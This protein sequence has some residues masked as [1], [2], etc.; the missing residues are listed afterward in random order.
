M[1]FKTNFL[2][3]VFAGIGSE[4]LSPISN[5]A[6]KI[7]TNWIHHHGP[8][9]EWKMALVCGTPL[10][11][12]PSFTQLK[13]LGILHLIVISGA[14]LVFFERF[15]LS[16][17]L[18]S[19]SFSPRSILMI[20]FL[21]SF[22]FFAG[23]QPPLVRAF[24]QRWK[25]HPLSTFRILHSALLSALFFRDFSLSLALSWACALLMTWPSERKRS[26]LFSSLFVLIGLYPLILPLGAPHFFTAFFQPAFSL[27]FGCFLFPLTLAGLALPLD[28]LCD[29]IWSLFFSLMEEVSN[30]GFEFYILKLPQL[31]PLL[32][33]LL[34][35]A[36]HWRAEVAFQRRT[37]WSKL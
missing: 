12:S 27:I 5:S 10:S 21:M 17:W 23:L 36:L 4:N 31:S 13:V 11:P 28:G 7:C 26:S 2:A 20:F 22:C 9:A 24:I 32:Y 25:T 33:T 15:F 37:L 29:F 35:Q 18:K 34:L 3:L 8:F 16:P 14:H 1:S 19:I 30:Q 6:Q